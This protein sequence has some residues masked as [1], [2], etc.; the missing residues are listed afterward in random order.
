MFCVVVGSTVTDQNT[1]MATPH[2]CRRR[3][4]SS[5][6]PSG[7]YRWSAR[8]YTRHAHNIPHCRRRPVVHLVS[9][10]IFFFYFS[11]SV[12]RVLCVF[13]WFSTVSYF[14]FFLL[15]FIR[16]RRLL[17]RRALTI[18]IFFFLSIKNN[19]TRHFLRSSCVVSRVSRDGPENSYERKNKYECVS[20]ACVNGVRSGK[21]SQYLFTERARR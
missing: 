4:F 7:P 11:K 21:M 12:S 9:Y 2:Y 5:P 19:Q 6:F 20:H 14:F 15:P 8:A 10:L 1:E 17:Q 16:R 13:F 18:H 3:F